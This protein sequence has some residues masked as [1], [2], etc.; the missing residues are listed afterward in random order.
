[1][2]TTKGQVESRSEVMDFLGTTAWPEA[3]KLWDLLKVTGHA[4]SSGPPL[5]LRSILGKPASWLPPHRRFSEYNIIDLWRPPTTLRF[6]AD[7]MLPAFATTTPDL[8]RWLLPRIVH[9]R[10]WRPTHFFRQPD[11]YGGVSSFPDEHWF[12]INGIATNADVARLNAAYLAHLFH[13]PVTVVQNA[14]QSILL[15][16][17]ECAIGK[18]FKNDPDSE[19]RK[20]MTE[21]AWRAT[22]A[23]LEALNSDHTRRVVIIAHSQ[24][25][26]IVA[27][28]LRAIAKA[29]RSDLVRQA[30][31]KWH[32]FTNSLIGEVKTDTQKILRDN[33]A[34]S[35]FEFAKGG[36]DAALERLS[37]L[38]IYTFANCADRMCHVYPSM[39]VPYMEHFANERDLVA[40]LGILSPLRAKTKPLIEIDGPMFVQKRAWGHLL[41]EHYLSSID[42]YLYPGACPRHREQNPYPRKGKG[43]S[44]SRLYE[45]FHGKRPA[46]DPPSRVITLEILSSRMEWAEISV[47]K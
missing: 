32:P 7:F 29:L 13:R 44:R 27:N 38:E 25:T 14:T 35:L 21:P 5:F 31:P 28:V 6:L 24:G 11:E 46:E 26:I 8:A 30:N 23:F 40:R 2:G 10:I 20:T 9:R 45:Y 15:D 17:G 19:D 34:H 42:E 39:E 43:P 16:L 33:L 12:F 37:K 18:G 22:A 36:P 3:N 41:N 47:P 4:A 1:M